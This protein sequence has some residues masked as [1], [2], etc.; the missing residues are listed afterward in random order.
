MIESSTIDLITAYRARGWDI[1]QTSWR[2]KEESAISIHWVYKSPRMNSNSMIPENF[3]D[4]Q[5]VLAE[6]QIYTRQL[7]AA[8]IQIQLQQLLANLIT[9]ISVAIRLR[10]SGKD[11]PLPIELTV[12]EVV[13]NLP[14]VEAARLS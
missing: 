7:Y 6:S 1:T 4:E 3:T 13:I 12:T 14:S 11:I 9:D 8:H 2:E 5:L 10:D